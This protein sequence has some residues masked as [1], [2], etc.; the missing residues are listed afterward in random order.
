M[1]LV[2]SLPFVAKHGL[3]EAAMQTW[4]EYGDIFRIKVGMLPLHFVAHPDGAERLLKT[5]RRNYIKGSA[6][7]TFRQLTG[8]GLLTAEGED[9]R[10]KRRRIQP[11]FAPRRIGELA[12]GMGRVTAATIEEWRELLPDGKT[13]PLEDEMIKVTLRI[14]GQTLFGIDIADVQDSST[15]AFADAMQ[16][17]SAGGNS[18]R[19]PLWV[20][21]P[22]NL[23][24]KRNLETL[25][26]TVFDIIKRGRAV[27]EGDGD[28]TLLQML[29]H[30]R[31][32]ESG[33]QFGDRELR[34]EVITMFL[35]GHET[36]ALTLTWCLHLLSRH[37]EVLDRV[38]VE[39]DREIGDT[40]P[41]MEDT[42]R[43]EYTRAVLDETLRL[44]P[45]AWAVARNAVEDDELMGYRIPAGG[46]V[47]AAAYIIH[48]HP[49]FWDEPER[50]NPD[51]FLDR[52][53]RHDFDNIP[54][55]RGPRMCIGAGFAVV[56]SLIVLAMLLRRARP[57]A[58]M[59]EDVVPRARVTLHPDRV[60]PMQLQWR[61]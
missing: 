28:P 56:E 49:E 13:F 47:V 50:F 4:R 54:F 31:D 1:P 60:I 48:H 32:D 27:P 61:S 18:M 43:L 58:M 40:V 19:I 57:K 29:I 22:R 55:S 15:A 53:P 7:D 46:I 14:V 41:T 26:D 38:V 5:H 44:R 52:T 25:D 35:A 24:M 8:N 37:P 59:E 10:K 36:T 34:D 6:Y 12:R 2:G 33:E 42:Q 30:A 11:A 45:P 23:R 16:F 3:L 17:A 9:W 39:I 20:P 21:T 51:R